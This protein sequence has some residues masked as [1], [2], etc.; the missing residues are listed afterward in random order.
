MSHRL[1]LLLV[2][3]TSWLS[4]LNPADRPS[5]ERSP[6]PLFP[7]AVAISPTDATIQSSTFAQLFSQDTD[8]YEAAKR[9]AK[10]AVAAGKTA[11][12]PQQWVEIARQWK[13]ASDLMEV[14][15]S[16]DD[17][18]EM[19]Q[20]RATLYRQNS[21]IA[22]EEVD[23][24]RARSQFPP[25]SSILRLGSTGMSVSQLQY[26]L[27]ALGYFEGEVSGSFGVNT[28]RAVSAFQKAQGLED[29]G[30]AGLTTWE[31]LTEAR[32]AIATP[33]PSPSPTEAEED[34]SNQ[35]NILNWGLIALACLS[36]VMAMV[37]VL[38]KLFNR[39]PKQQQ[40]LVLDDAE[41]EDS[42]EQVMTEAEPL[43]GETSN[44]GNLP[45]LSEAQKSD[46]SESLAVGNNLRLAK[47]DI[48]N[49]LIA[50]LQSPDLQKRR[51]A[52]WELGQRGTS[53]AAQPLVNL[54]I[55]SDSVQRGLILAALS[56]IGVRTL[57]P[58]NRALALSLQDNNP[59]VRK[60]AIRDLTRV[61][62]VIAQVNQLVRHA[63]EDPD[64]EVRQTA[65]WALNQLRR[66]CTVANPDSAPTANQ[67]ETPSD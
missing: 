5:L 2:S 38:V 65:T 12:T 42:L 27:K 43:N 24:S 32:V 52:I 63:L 55:D 7:A 13:Q 11:Y 20:E 18:Y 54:L 29:D 58:L 47:I 66:I 8:S 17:R 1:I 4:V 15:E 25:F 64:P 33:R 44:N 37:L 3:Y 56:E 39:A 59:E 35:R 51:Q 49:E 34:G 41:G 45:A 46:T 40:N 30:I 53:Q 57:K 14:V 28:A 10:E 62:E 23:K 48:V 19:A 22:L 21:Q 26:R 50:E 16:D 9:L 36:A 31:R 60:N 6:R 67:P 61:Y